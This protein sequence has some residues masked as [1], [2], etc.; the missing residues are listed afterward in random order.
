MVRKEMPKGILTEK[1]WAK[2]LPMTT[3]HWWCG[4]GE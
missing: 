3:P 4:G 1:G 2:L